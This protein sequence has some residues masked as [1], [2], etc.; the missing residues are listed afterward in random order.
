MIHITIKTDNA[1]F[2]NDDGDGK[3]EGPEVA[4]IL[5][6]LADKI[7]DEADLSG[8]SAP[9]LDVNGNKVGRIEAQP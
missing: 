6:Y 2:S 4:R 5:R 9:C 3:A 1:A 8:Y 7:E